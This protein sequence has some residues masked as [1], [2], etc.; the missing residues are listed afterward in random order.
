MRELTTSGCFIHNQASLIHFLQN[1]FATGMCTTLCSVLHCVV[2]EAKH[3]GVFFCISSKLTKEVLPL[4]YKICFATNESGLCWNTVLH[5]C[6][7]K[8]LRKRD[9]AKGYFFL[10]VFVSLFQWHSSLPKNFSYKSCF[11]TNTSDVVDNCWELEE[12]WW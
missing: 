7:G 4:I 9:P 12:N 11:A 3:R 2:C 8:L 5:K 6:W 1:C 10:S